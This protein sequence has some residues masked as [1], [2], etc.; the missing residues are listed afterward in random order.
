M[1]AGDVTIVDGRVADLTNLSGTFRFDEP[2]GLLAV[3]N[4]LAHQGFIIDPT[5]VRLF[6]LDGSRPVV[7]R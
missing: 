2:E 4:E 3:A 1:Y 6:P 5:A 7:L